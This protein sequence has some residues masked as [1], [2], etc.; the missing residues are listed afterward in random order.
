MR[1]TTRVVVFL[2]LTIGSTSA[3][4]VAQEL[5]DWSGPYVGINA[6]ISAANAAIGSSTT[7]GFPGS[8]FTPPDPDQ[9]GSTMAG[10]LG[11]SRVAPGLFAGYGYQV[12]SLYFGIE[13]GFSSLGFEGTRS[14]SA[15]YI[16]NP[17]GRFTNTVSARADWQASIRARLGWANEQ[18]LGYV[19]A[20]PAFSSVNMTASFSDDFVG[21]G[22]FGTATKE[23][24][25]IGLALGAGAEINLGKG[26]ALRGEYL[27]SDF[28]P[29]SSPM[30]ISNPA[31]PVLANTLDSSVHLKTHSVSV[32]LSYRF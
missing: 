18:W 9:I 26:W 27:Y 20:G 12:D 21:A 30:S 19:T 23:Q 14:V 1:H 32:G 5:A 6:S 15:D 8:Y 29:L 17:T 10:V 28:G 16:S 25:R 11:T 2:S 24:V 4:A 7:D 3:N 31:F 13:G 22:A